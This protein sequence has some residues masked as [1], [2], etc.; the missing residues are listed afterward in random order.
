MEM[1]FNAVLGD[2]VNRSMSFLFAKCERQ[3]TP[4][5]QEG[6]CRLR[7]LLL[8]SGAIV[9]EAQR[10]HVESRAMRLQ[11]KALMEETLKAYYV[12][13]SVRCRSALAA[14]QGGGDDGGDG[15]A[16]EDGKGS[17][18]ALALSRTNPAKR[19]RPF[20]LAAGS[21]SSEPS[22]AE[23]EKMIHRLLVMIND[24][25]EFVVFLM[26]CPPMYR[27]PYSAHLLVEKSMFG[28]HTETE[29]VMEFLLQPTTPAAAGNMG[30]LPIIGS[31]HIGKTTLVEHVCRDERVCNHFSLIL[32]YS[33]ND[34]VK[35]EGPC[36]F[37]DKCVIKHQ[38]SSNSEKRTLIVIEVRD[39]VDEE[40]WEW[41]YSPERTMAAKGSRMIIT[42][43]SESIGRFGTT[44]ALKLNCLSLEA[45]WYHFKMLTF[46]SDDPTQN[47]K[48]ESLAM[49]IA[50]VLQGSFMSAWMAAAVLR[51]NF[52]T[53]SWTK[54][55]TRMRQYIQ[56][57]TSLIGEYMDDIKSKAHRRYVWS[58]IEPRPD[59]Y[60]MLDEIF[61]VNPA[62]EAEIPKITMIDLVSAR[63]AQ[64][65][66]KYDIL[67]WKAA[68]PPYYSYV[69][70]CEVTKI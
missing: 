17:H 52:D 55:L 60:F 20:V 28:R 46:G 63:C 36:S 39:D 13:D 6:M 35:D 47:P 67:Y 24:M 7:H 33:G 18:R 32:F 26:S 45:S 65:Q 56:K 2:L 8:R 3:A 66:G 53:E 23:L 34:L 54:V 50:N 27:Q 25:R 68:I 29:M 12:L 70:T 57:N 48:M 49:E 41:I 51:A 19:L 38:N 10:R 22:T 30:V 62:S 37:R 44:E 59:K 16:K 43:R 61:P 4:D 9:E 11:L 5:A 69:C 31:I 58:L 42:S 1:F 64:P 21:G 15:E 14:A 40:T